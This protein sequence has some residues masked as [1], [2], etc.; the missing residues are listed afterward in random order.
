MMTYPKREEE[1]DIKK[2]RKK[3]LIEPNNAKKAHMLFIFIQ[4]NNSP[5]LTDM[6]YQMRFNICNQSTKLSSYKLSV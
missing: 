4:N 2:R 1:E 6:S 3:R 5:F